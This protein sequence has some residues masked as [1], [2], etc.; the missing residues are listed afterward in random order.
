[1]K[2]YIRSNDLGRYISSRL[3][4]GWTASLLVYGAEESEDYDFEQSFSGNF[5]NAL[6]HLRGYQEVIDAN[7]IDGYLTLE[8]DDSNFYYEGDYDSIH[9]ELDRDGL[10][11]EGSAW[12]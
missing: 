6:R 4:T 1:M 7:H 9:D 8:S 10:I 3:M 11:A 2:R 12:T 5:S